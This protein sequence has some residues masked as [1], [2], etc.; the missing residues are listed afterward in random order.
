[1]LPVA[2][3]Y[4]KSGEFPWDLAKKAHDLGLMNINV[5]THYG[6]LGLGCFDTCLVTEEFAYG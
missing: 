1:M 6:G 4:D 5:P 2:A 3:K